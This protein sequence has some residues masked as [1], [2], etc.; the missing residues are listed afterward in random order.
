VGRAFSRGRRGSAGAGS[1]GGNSLAPAASTSSSSTTNIVC[2]YPDCRVDLSCDPSLECMELSRTMLAARPLKEAQPLAYACLAQVQVECITCTTISSNSN[3]GSGWYGDYG[4][5][6]AHATCHTGGSINNRNGINKEHIVQALIPPP[7]S[8]T[9]K[10]SS[11]TH[12]LV[13]GLSNGAVGGNNAPMSRDKRPM[14]PKMLSLP[15]MFT[16]DHP[17]SSGGGGGANVNKYDNKQQPD[18]SG[19][20]DESK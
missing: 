18:E 9:S 4:D 16:K 2:P 19:V 12:H 14:F 10:S 11:P 13:G 17:N 3:E 1:R 20:A 6:L 7:S 5:Y 15:S 8:N